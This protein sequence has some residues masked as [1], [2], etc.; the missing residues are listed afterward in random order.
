MNY[1]ILDADTFCGEVDV[2]MTGNSTYDTNG[3]QMTNSFVIEDCFYVDMK[4]PVISDFPEDE[5]TAGQDYTVRVTVQDFSEVDL[6]MLDYD[7]GS[8]LNT[9]MMTFD[10]G[11]GK[12]VSVVTV[13]LD[14]T[15]LS[16]R[17]SAYDIYDNSVTSSFY[18]LNI[19]A[20]IDERNETD[21]TDDD[22]G[23]EDETDDSSDDSSDDED[24]TDT[25]DPYTQNQTDDGVQDSTPGFEIILLFI[26]CAFLIFV[27]KRKK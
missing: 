20:D 26:A 5:L 6:V 24:E 11:S 3:V 21:S 10:P 16:Y 1:T 22:Q 27:Q 9:K 25:D 2:V 4:A 18:L 7:F 23:S 13:P 8:N 19:S 17:V 12:Y 14:A 15:N